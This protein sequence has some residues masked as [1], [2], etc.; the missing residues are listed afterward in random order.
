[1]LRVDRVECGYG[2][3]TA[4]RDA[5]LTV[6]PGE[7]VCIVGPNGAGKTTLVSNIAGMFT[8]RSGRIVLNDSEIGGLGA[9]KVARL[10]V[11]LV[12][13]GR[14]IFGSLTVEENL[15]LGATVRRGDGLADD[16]DLALTRFPILRERYRSQAGKLSGGEQ[17]MLAI[18]RALMSRPRLI[19]IDEPSLGLAPLVVD[20]VY[21]VLLELRNQQALGMIVVEQSTARIADIAT[22]LHVV[23]TGR[24]VATL[25][26]DEISSSTALDDAYFG[27]GKGHEQNLGH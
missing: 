16:V 26:G 3:F 15:R 13:E 1:M 25:D 5:S 2:P 11:S 14:R 23:R 19:M 17:Q 12:P 27:F 24:I 4:L 8:P 21:E 18:A 10:G 7:C 9:E 22:R 6:A 20:K